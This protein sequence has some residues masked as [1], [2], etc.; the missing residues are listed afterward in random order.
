MVFLAK[1]LVRKMMTVNPEKRFTV[2]QALQHPWIKGNSTKELPSVKV[3]L[4]NSQTRKTGMSPIKIP[5]PHDDSDTEEEMSPTV[6][7]NKKRKGEEET[8][9]KKLPKKLSFSSNVQ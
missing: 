7:D 4:R 2:E 9:S 8:N 6:T 5:A 3:N 1:D